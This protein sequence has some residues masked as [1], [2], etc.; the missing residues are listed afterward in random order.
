[1]PLILYEVGG[2][3][4]LRKQKIPTEGFLYTLH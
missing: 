3:F 2:I 4:C 1:M